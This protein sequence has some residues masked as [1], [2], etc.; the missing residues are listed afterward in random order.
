MSPGNPMSGIIGLG[1]PIEDQHLG[2]VSE[3]RVVE[4]GE[5]I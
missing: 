3:A 1:G 2:N 5:S 4:V